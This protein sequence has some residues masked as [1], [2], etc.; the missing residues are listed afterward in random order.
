MEAKGGFPKEIVLVAG[1]RVA[2]TPTGL[3]PGDPMGVNFSIYYVP[4]GL[5]D[6]EVTLLKDTF[7]ELF[8]GE[9]L[10]VFDTELQQDLDKKTS[11]GFLPPCAPS[12]KALVLQSLEFR[13]AKLRQEMGSK[14]I[15]SARDIAKKLEKQSSIGG[16]DPKDTATLRDMFRHYQSLKSLIDNYNEGQKC[17]SMSDKAFGNLEFDL[18]DDRAKELLRQFIFFTLQAHHPLQEY[19]KT[20]PTAPQF[21]KRLETNPIGEKFKPFLTTYQGNKLPIP[22]SIARVLESVEGTSGVIDEQLKL[23][24]AEAIDKE[25]EKIIKLLLTFF[26][27]DHR[28]WSAVGKEKDLYKIVDTLLEYLKLADGESER[29]TKETIR[30]TEAL[31]RCEANSQLLTSNYGRIE[32]QV[33][34]LQ[35]KLEAEGGKDKKIADLE[36]ALAKAK[37]EHAARLEENA[38]EMERYAAQ[39][40]ANEA[41]IAAITNENVALR[42]RIRELEDQVAALRDVEQRLNAK[43]AELRRLVEEHRAAIE[44]E[45]LRTAEQRLAK[46]KAEGERTQAVAQLE[47]ARVELRGQAAALEEN[48]AQLVTLRA[49]IDKLTRQKR[50]CDTETEAL[51]SQL[52][53]LNA[54]LRTLRAEQAQFQQQIEA[55]EEEIR[56]VTETA[57][58]EK[59]DLEDTIRKLREE[60]ARLTQEATDLESRIRACE[61]E[62]AALEGKASEPEARAAKLSADLAAAQAQLAAAEREKQRLQDENNQLR[63]QIASKDDALRQSGEDLTAARAEATAQ[64]GRATTAEATIGSLESQVGDLEARVASKSDEAAAEAARRREDAAAHETKLQALTNEYKGLLQAKTSELGEATQR[65]EA[66]RAARLAETE[67]L[68]ASQEA[69]ERLQAA[70]EALLTGPEGAVNEAIAK[71]KEEDTQTKSSLQT[72][73]R[74]LQELEVFARERAET[75][76][77]PAEEAAEKKLSQCYNVFLLTYLWQTYFP[78]GAAETQPFLRK[79]NGIFSGLPAITGLYKSHPTGTVLEYLN[80]L[81]KLLSLFDGETVSVELTPKEKECFNLFIKLLPIIQDVD[82]TASAVT[83][84]PSMSEQARLYFAAHGPKADTFETKTETNAETGQETVTPLRV[85]LREQKEVKNKAE[86]PV[87]KADIV[88]LASSGQINFSLLYF[89]FLVVMRDYLNTITGS[90][91]RCPLP[92]ILQGPNYRPPPAARKGS[93]SSI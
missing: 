27:G 54:E 17:V 89:C 47:A 88:E 15:L 91:G 40:A 85:V 70:I 14:G 18:T 67:K 21:I 12:Q 73:Y 71:I 1:E 58:E 26:P 16:V 72:I 9:S 66:E 20:N 84:T 33:K 7:Q 55:K 76:L 3:P 28:F 83:I 5:K 63:G 44:A 92:K 36:A 29:L 46:E 57:E 45:Q 90:L 38:A 37:A 2:L 24:L 8:G 75:P 42:A 87:R 64:A 86:G 10:P 6:S 48:R 78:A 39:I 11:K 35:A 34:D 25:K 4:E 59:E 30:L 52:A 32:A 81:I 61:A 53:A 19:K 13:M 65:I 93:T 23:R 82:K 79:I 51:R 43:D 74:K 68:G 31:R 41:S 22:E 80:L 60:I 56:R 69:Y 49:E 62:K 50:D 77:T